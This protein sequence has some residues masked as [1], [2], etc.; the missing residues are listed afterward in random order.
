VVSW[1]L[2][3]YSQ[4]RLDLNIERGTLDGFQRWGYSYKLLE[5]A[6]KD[7]LHGE[8]YVSQPKIRWNQVKSGN[9]KISTKHALAFR[10]TQVL[11]SDV[12][13]VAFQIITASA[14]RLLF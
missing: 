8:F 12:L 1:C 7:K 10:I 13:L 14:C 9:T 6:V 3:P 2:S 4:T 5:Y 11:V